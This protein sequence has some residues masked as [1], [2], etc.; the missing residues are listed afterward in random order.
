MKITREQ[1]CEMDNYDKAIVAF[2]CSF[3]PRSE[4]IEDEEDP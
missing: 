4:V 3:Q 2:V 1:F